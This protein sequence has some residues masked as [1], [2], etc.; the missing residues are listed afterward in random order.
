MANWLFAQTTHVVGSKVKIKVCMVGGLRCVVIYVKCDPN[1]LRGYGAV[2]CWKWPFPIT[3]ASGLYNSL[4]YRT[5]RDYIHGPLHSQKKKNARFYRC[6]WPYIFD[7]TSK[8]DTF[9]HSIH[10]AEN[11]VKLL[12]RPGRLIILD[13]SFFLQGAHNSKGDPFSGGAKYNGVEFFCD[14]RLKSPSISETEQDR[15]GDA[16]EH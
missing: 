16:M 4:Y 12:C 9:V 2:R 1:R 8:S 6:H 3:L 13:F 7:K 15:P 14:F 11:I 10:T 5:S